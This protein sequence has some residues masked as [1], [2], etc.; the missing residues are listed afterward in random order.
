[1]R[2]LNKFSAIIVAIFFLLLIGLSTSCDKDDDLLATNHQEPIS[3]SVSTL[4]YLDSLQ[5]SYYGYYIPGSG[6]AGQLQWNFQTSQLDTIRQYYKISNDTLTWIHWN[7]S[8]DALWSS[9]FVPC[10]G[11][12]CHYIIT[13]ID[14]Y[15]QCNNGWDAEVD[16]YVDSS[17]VVLKTGTYIFTMY[18][19]H[20][21]YAD[22]SVLQTQ[23]SNMYPFALRYDTPFELNDTLQP[24]VIFGSPQTF[25]PIKHNDYVKLNW[26]VGDDIIDGW[27]LYIKRNGEVIVNGMVIPKNQTQDAYKTYYDYYY[28]E[29]GYY[30]YSVKSFTSFGVSEI[31]NETSFNISNNSQNIPARVY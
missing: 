9:Y 8:Q 11:T 5:G 4:T 18:R 20:Q 27:L 10:E 28:D 31:S 6:G 21:S 30:S 22:T 14:V 19:N 1:M 16:Y 12:D 15:Y 23:I 13:D 26:V 3:K 24:D 17:G 29:P 7:E 25:D 2:T